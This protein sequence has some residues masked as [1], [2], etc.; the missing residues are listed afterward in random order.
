MIVG[1][2][3]LVLLVVLSLMEPGVMNVLLHE[4]LGWL[5]LALIATLELLGFVLI[6]RIVAIEI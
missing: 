4:P 5:A 1:A 6:R 3:P 2:L